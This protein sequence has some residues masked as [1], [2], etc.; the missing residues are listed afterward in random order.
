MEDDAEDGWHLLIS[1]GGRPFRCPLPPDIKS[2]QIKWLVDHLPPKVKLQRSSSGR[3]SFDAP[4]AYQGNDVTDARLDGLRSITQQ[5]TEKKIE[6]IELEREVSAHR[7]ELQ[8]L[9]HQIEE[10]RKHAHSFTGTLTDLM[11]AW[12]KRQPKKK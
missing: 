7:L 9:T 8:T 3:E 6:L 5:L 10:R 4:P 1:T 12:E 2:S 11:Q